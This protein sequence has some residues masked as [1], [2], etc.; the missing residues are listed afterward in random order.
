MVR[1]NDIKV[2]STHNEETSTVAEIFIR[3]LRNKIYKYMT[4]VSKTFILIN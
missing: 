1:K 4:L 3:N 2:Y